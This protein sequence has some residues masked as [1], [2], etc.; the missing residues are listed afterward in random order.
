[1]LDKL[2]TLSLGHNRLDLVPAEIANLRALRTL[3]LSHN[4]LTILC[5][6]IGWLPKLESLNVSEN[7]LKD[8]PE[9]LGDL[10]LKE[11]NC[12]HNEFANIVPAMGMLK[13]ERLNLEGGVITALAPEVLVTLTNLRE[14]NLSHNRLTT[15]PEEL[16]ALWM[17]R[18]INLSH[19]PIELTAWPV[20]V[21][22]LQNVRFNWTAA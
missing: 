14:L 10:N 8:L 3:D 13:L 7:L 9:T 15:V 21:R 17:L 19:N 4:Q 20:K 11:F 18:E 6:E 1:M 5:P 16:I 22:A 2:E 12:Q